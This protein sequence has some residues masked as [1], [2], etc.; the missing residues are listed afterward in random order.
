MTRTPHNL[1]HWS[2]KFRHAF[3]GLRVGIHGQSSFYVH[4]AITAL[5]FAAA[6]VLQVSLVEWC[7]LLVCIG[8]VLA[9][10]LFNSAIE[11]LGRAITDD[12]HEDIRDALDV[13]SGAVLIAAIFAAIVGTTILVFRLGL[14]LGWWAGYLLI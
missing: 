1:R 6:L 7:I 12:Y 13:A 3:R 2:H 9:A 14:H 8:M 10:E 5:V 4:F 11:S